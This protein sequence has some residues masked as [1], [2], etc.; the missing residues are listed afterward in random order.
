MDITLEQVERLRERADISYEEAKTLLEQCGGDLLEAL[1]LLER[2]GSA[3]PTGQG[4]FYSTRPG[5]VEQRT[6][7]LILTDASQSK[8]RDPRETSGFG[9]Q[10]RELLLAFLN[11]LRHSLANQFEVWRGGEQLT[12]IPILILII[13]L[14]VAFWIVVPLLIVALFFG[15]QYRFSGPDMNREKANEVMD[16]V[17]H[18]VGRM[19]DQVKERVRRCAAREKEKHKKS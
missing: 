13:L 5:S 19:V 8:Q 18:S 12:S 3:T 1:I 11:L 6:A 17:S 7:A 14:I 16:K 10:F 4:G 2:M 15:C 9:G